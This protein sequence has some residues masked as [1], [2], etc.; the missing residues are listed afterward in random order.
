MTK[1]LRAAVI[2]VGHLGR[3]HA[4]IYAGCDDVDLVAVIDTNE[5][6]ARY[7]GELYGAEPF[8]DVSRL[9]K[10]IDIASV[11]VPTDSHFAMSKVLLERGVHLLI[12]K[13]M[14][15]T[16]DE[17]NEL[18]DL[19]RSKGALIQVG[20]IERFNPA[21][22][23]LREILTEPRFIEV[24]RLARYKQRGT[25]VGVV[26]DLMIHDIDVVLSL[27]NSPVREVRGV[28]VAILS[29][30]EDIANARIEFKNGCIA[31]LTASKVSE[32]KMRKIRIFQR[33]AYISL[34]YHRQEGFIYRTEGE[35]ITRRKV[36]VERGEPLKLE[37]DSFIECVR[38]DARP[39]VPGEH[40]RNALSIAME[41][42]G[43]IK[44]QPENRP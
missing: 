21:L 2:G 33:N 11:V 12:E 43:Q 40:G 1:K 13:P 7:V 27:V 44:N 42:V 31:N 18:L 8:G 3:E 34:D 20:H 10:P 26:L 24:H 39:L 17:A 36:P 6:V 19:A 22:L 30:H 38:S 4:R 28:G 15:E 41:V 5:D 9:D 29:P 32:K 25:E 37:I 16:V 23:A 14:T 35:R